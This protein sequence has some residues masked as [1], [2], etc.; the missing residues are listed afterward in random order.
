MKVGDK[1]GKILLLEKIGRGSH[2]DAMW[3][4]Q[5][6]CGNVFYRYTSSVKKGKDC[7]CGI[8]KKNDLTGKKFGMLTA[9]KKVGTDKNG[10]A[11]WLCKCDCG[12]MTVVS[13][14]NLSINKTKTISCGCWRTKM[15]T[16]HN[17]ANSKI[18]KTYTAMKQRCYN[19]N[20]PAYI[21][22]GSRGIKVC[23]EWTDKENGFENFYNWAT[24]NGYQENLTLDRIDN[25]GN[26]EP[27]N[28]RWVTMEYQ[29]NNK[30]NNRYITYKGETHTVAEWAKK[31]NIPYNKVYV[32]LVHKNNL[33]ILE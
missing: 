9:L 3:K 13:R 4:C 15:I 32:E 7:G 8:K 24:S 30:R 23:D 14:A 22:Y 26:Y 27:S 31:A 20:N 18:Y 29:D 28:C 1:I 21:Y 6:D 19:Q 16:R 11:R 12:N 5:C 2:K 17:H 10:E 25:N 33:K